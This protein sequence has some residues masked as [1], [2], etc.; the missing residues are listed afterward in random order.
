[1]DVMES[2]EILG[3]KHTL[4]QKPNTHVKPSLA[5]FNSNRADDVQNLNKDSPSPP[6]HKF[7]IST[8]G[9]LKRFTL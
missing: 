7:Q 2:L 1:M 4:G 6:N 8:V 3:T 9:G 5:L